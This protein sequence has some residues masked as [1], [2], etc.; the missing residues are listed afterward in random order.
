MNAAPRQP[1]R[2]YGVDDHAIVARGLRAAIQVEADLE[3]AG[4]QPMADGLVEAVDEHRPDVILL[5][6]DMPGAD[7]FVELSDLTE[8]RDHARVLMLTS[9][10]RE[11]S[12]DAAITSGARGFVSKSM[13]FDELF[14]AIRTVAGGGYVFPEEVMERCEIID[15]RLTLTGE[16]TSKLSRLT[17]REM[18]VLRLIAFGHTTKEIADQIHRS[19]KR[20]ESIRTSVM[21]KLDCA[22]RLELT[23]LAI[24]EGIVEA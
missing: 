21:R 6:I 2:V 16:T 22:D 9:S 4:W 15:G 13:E 18:Q 17:P 12:I 10:T 20:V 3:W 24:R 19:V 23:R 8:L 1:I 7:A 5:D 11:R 14:D